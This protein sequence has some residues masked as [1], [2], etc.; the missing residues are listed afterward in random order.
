MAAV[1]RRA[2]REGTAGGEIGPPD[3]ALGS[4]AR[5]EEVTGRRASVGL[6]SKQTLTMHP[7]RPMIQPHGRNITFLL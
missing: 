7:N 2:D 1:K 4:A 6:L 3:G 5:G